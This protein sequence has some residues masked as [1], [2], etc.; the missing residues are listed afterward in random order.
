MVAVAVASRF[1]F[2]ASLALACYKRVGG[3]RAWFGS[4]EWQVRDV[5]QL[6]DRS[7]SGQRRRASVARLIS[8]GT[9]PSGM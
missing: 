2:L 4:E 8:G 6:L 7:A 3:A 1:G 5:P 9:I